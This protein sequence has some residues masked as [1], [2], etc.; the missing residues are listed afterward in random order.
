MKIQNIRT[1]LLAISFLVVVSACTEQKTSFTVVKNDIGAKTAYKY[2][3]FDCHGENGISNH[4]QFPNLAGQNALYIFH[5][6]QAF[7]RSGLDRKTNKTSAARF[8]E[9]MSDVSIDLS[10]QEMKELATFFT[11][12]S[13]SAI[14]KRTSPQIVKK[15]KSLVFCAQCHGENG[16]S[17]SEEIP[18]LAGQ[19]KDYLA[20]ELRLFRAAKRGVFD[21]GTNPASLR[22]H[23][24][25]NMNASNLNDTEIDDLAEYFSVQNCE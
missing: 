16:I 15:P 12:Q 14:K 24:I 6:L 3:C 18:N 9:L 22:D 23:D 4:P 7:K 2:R 20:M 1:S 17:L 11:N 25:M 19:K 8:N 13:C 5:Q 21:P 10:E